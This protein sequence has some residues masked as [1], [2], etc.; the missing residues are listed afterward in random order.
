[1]H[2]SLNVKL[3]KLYYRVIGRGI[4]KSTAIFEPVTETTYTSH[5]ITRYVEKTKLYRC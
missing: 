3:C 4:L 1:M 2:G 5:V